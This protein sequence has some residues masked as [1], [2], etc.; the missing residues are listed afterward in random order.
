MIR[1][2]IGELA[3]RGGVGIET[4]RYYQRRHLIPEPPRKAKGFREYSDDTL[5]TLRF[6]RRAKGLGFTLK[7]IG[8]LLTMRAAGKRVQDQLLDVLVEKRRDLEERADEIQTAIRALGRLTEQMTRVAPEERW[9]VL[10]PEMD[11]PVTE[12]TE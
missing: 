7:E 4:V 2:T 10:E 3:R 12:P 1:M 5:Q 11:V 8:R 6:I 9:S